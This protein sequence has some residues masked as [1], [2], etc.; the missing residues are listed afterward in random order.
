M[1]GVR[2]VAGMPQ[3]FVKIKDGVLVLAIAKYVDDILISAYSDEW[4]QFARDG[5]SQCYDVGSWNETPD[6]IDVNATQVF[7]NP[8]GVE[9]H[10]KRMSKEIDFVLLSPNRRKDIAS[11]V[12]KMEQRSVRTLAGKL[13]YIGV[14]KSPLAGFAASFIQQIIPRMTIAGV[15]FA[16][17][18]A[19]DALKRSNSITYLNPSKEERS[20][21]T[22]VVFSDA[23]FPHKGVEK[24]VAQEGCIFG[25]AYGMKKNSIF[26]TLGWISRKQRRVSHSSGQAETIA[27]VTSLGCGMNVQSVWCSITSQKLPTTLVVDNLG[28][29]RC[30]LTQSKPTD[31]A[32]LNDI[33]ALRLDYEAKVVDN[34]SWIS[35]VL[36]PANSLTK[37]HAGETSG[38]LESLLGDGRL[39]VDVDCYFPRGIE[40]HEEC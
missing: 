14:C 15:K 37:P 20:S 8:H 34:V 12:S 28:L 26:H 36:N 39:P 35:G 38:L 18:I 30:L 6:E 10:S 33:H 29:H 23:G 11:E 4:L 21:E 9:I 3:L 7:Q 24:K 25:I 31:T 32:M 5:I 19:K 27:A 16:N 13:G 40:K 22:I 2:A 17:G 1:L